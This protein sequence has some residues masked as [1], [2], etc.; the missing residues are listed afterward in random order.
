M[1]NWFY[2]MGLASPNVVLC[3]PCIFMPSSKPNAFLWICSV[4]NYLLFSLMAISGVHGCFWLNGCSLPF[5]SYTANKAMLS[6]GYHSNIS[7]KCCSSQKYRIQKKILTSQNPACKRCVYVELLDKV[8][9]PYMQ[10]S[11]VRLPLL[12]GMPPTCVWVMPASAV[13]SSPPSQAE[14]AV[15][16]CCCSAS[17]SSLRLPGAEVLLLTTPPDT[18]APAQVPWPAHPGASMGPGNA[19][20]LEVS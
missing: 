15:A 19:A 20:S 8:V 5:Q 11:A 17:S 7:A 16:G 18:P 1:E 2:S 6:Q 3:V 12:P 14:P 10:P 4:I 9:Q 13:S